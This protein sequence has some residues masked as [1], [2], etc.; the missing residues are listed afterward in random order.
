MAY[1][2]ANCPHCGT[3][4][5]PFTSVAFVQRHNKADCCNGFF[6]CPFCEKPISV[7]M[8]QQRP[9][10]GCHRSHEI[11]SWTKTVQAGGWRVTDVWPAPADIEAPL[12]TPDNVAR[13]FVEAEESAKR[14]HRES[15]GMAYRRALELTLK[16]K[17]PTL[18]GTLEKRID[19]LAD[20]GKLTPDMAEWAHSIRTLGNEATHDEDVPTAEDI[21]D[22]AA[23]TRIVLEYIYTMPA[24]VARRAAPP[25]QC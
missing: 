23:F 15:A 18:R 10:E 21:T 3:K 4:Q 8:M 7:W 6:V 12:D 5:S 19:A 20:G 14:N 24:K 11:H 2:A 16:D 1:L 22:L 25:V 13:I 9:V 17:A